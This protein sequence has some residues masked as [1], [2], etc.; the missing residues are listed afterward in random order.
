MDRSFLSRPEVIAASRQ[1]V[2]IRLATYENADEA[3][4]LKSLLRTRTGE[5]ENSVF[6]VLSPD[7][8]SH[9]ARAGRSP[10]QTFG[11][12]E[13]M[14]EALMQIAAPFGPAPPAGERP[15]P[16]VANVRLAIDI[17]A[18]DNQPLVVVFAPD[19]SEQQA[20]ERR[21][22]PLAWGDRFLGR[23]VYV[24]C[25]DAL[26]LGTVAGFL[27]Q[28]GVMLLQPDRFG[29]MATLLRQASATVGEPELI[30]A[31]QEGLARFE[32]EYKLFGSH[33]RTGQRQGIFWETL[34]PV[35]D[36]DERRVRERGRSQ[37]H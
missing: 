1:F 8:K 28:P 29:Q 34:L 2:C 22:R 21:L 9:L 18:C 14:A 37:A 19:A 7:G 17:A 23:F 32:P 4:L 11:N 20:L 10:K 16:L 31:L 24:S 15:L 36:P 12:A 33:I 25:S 30:R 35:T 13:R 27:P 5:L 3:R 26:E 6:A